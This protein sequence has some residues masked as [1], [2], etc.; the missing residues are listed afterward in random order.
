MKQNELISKKLIKVGKILSY[1]EHLLILASAI[2]RCV[3][4]FLVGILADIANSVA[5]LKICVITAGV[6]N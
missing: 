1:T 6:K 2:T 4:A 3:F 5:T